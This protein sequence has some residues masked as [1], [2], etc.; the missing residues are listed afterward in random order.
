MNNK[1]S[2]FK[3]SVIIP[4]YNAANFVRMAVESAVHLDAIGEV[5]LVEDKSPDN[6]LAVCNK[7]EEQYS[8]VKV[9][10]HPNGENRGAGASRNLGIV[11]AKF[12]Y[13]AFLDADD[14]YLSNRFSKTTEIF[15]KYEDCD[16]VYEAV[17]LNIHDEVG[18][19]LFT[20]RFKLESLNES[21][22]TTIKT[23][24]LPTKLFDFLLNS[25]DERF[26]TIGLCVRK[27]VFDKAGYFNP[28]LKLH[29]DSELWLRIAYYC[30]LYPGQVSKA[31]SIRRVHQ[32][33]RS[34]VKDIIN[35]YNFSKAVFNHFYYKP[36]L[37]RSQRLLIF[38]RYLL[39]AHKISK[40]RAINVKLFTL[41]YLLNNPKIL[42]RLIR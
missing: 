37:K 3:V 9:L 20:Q 30:R 7:L 13:I 24:V 15:D 25:K 1:I 21:F 26:S 39:A 27:K 29:Q 41:L 16:G 32:D 38:K 33:N 6:A 2:I 5:I 23:P 34:N 42:I 11:N 40:W 10:Q 28:N 17:G 31:V 22:L 4:V 18:R 12:E 35:T 8:K 19:N 36:E 14:Y